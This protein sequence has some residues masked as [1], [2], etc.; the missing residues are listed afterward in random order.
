MQEYPLLLVREVERVL[1]E[2]AAPNRPPYDEV[3]TM[4]N[5]LTKECNEFRQYCCSH[6]VPEADCPTIESAGGMEEV[7]G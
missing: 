1:V 2:A 3:A 4:V 7:V 6:G 5:V